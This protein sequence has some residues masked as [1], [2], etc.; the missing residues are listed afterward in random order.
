[1]YQQ[2]AYVYGPPVL[3]VMIGKTRIKT[4]SDDDHC[5]EDD[6]QQPDD[7]LPSRLGK[8]ELRDLGFLQS[9]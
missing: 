7:P 6:Q 1:M 5:P 2:P 4:Q 3:V 9:Q 8:N